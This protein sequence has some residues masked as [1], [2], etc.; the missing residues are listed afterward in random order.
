MARC[1]EI[2][3]DIAVPAVRDWAG[4]KKG[5][6]H[7]RGK[8]PS[9]VQLLGDACPQLER[10]EGDSVARIE[11]VCFDSGG[12]LVRAG[13]RV[14][15]EASADAQRAT[16]S[17][18]EPFSPGVM[19]RSAV[20]DA[21]IDAPGDVQPDAPSDATPRPAGLAAISFDDAPAAF[22]EALAM[23][24][25]LQPA[26][27]LA[28]ARTRWTWPRPDDVVIDVTLDADMGPPDRAEP[29]LHELRLSIALPDEPG[30]APGR[31]V[32]AAAWQALFAAARDALAALPAFVQLTDYADRTCRNRVGAA[33]TAV[34]AG[35]VDLSGARTQ[36]E[37]LAIIGRN[38][39]EHWFG[40][41]TGVR[42]AADTEFVHQMRV[43][44]RRLRT[45]MRLFKGW[46]DEAWADRIEPD[47]KWLGKLLGNARDRDVFVDSTLPALANADTDAA[48]W[49]ATREA[50]D[51]QRLAAR[52]KVQE[53][54]ASRRYAN[55]ALAWLEWQ[56]AL[57]S[58]EAP[59]NAARQSLAKHARKRIRKPYRRLVETPKLTT[60]DEK[61]RHSVRIE[62]KRLR[63]ALEF[64]ESIVSRKT[65]VE[66]AKTLSRIQSVLGDGNDAAVALGYLDELN[67]DAYQQGFAR[68][69]CEAVKRYT[70]R[71]GERLL[72]DLDAPKIVGGD[73]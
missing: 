54:M 43:A 57:L 49:A 1:I 28:F 11:S 12:A 44:Q 56:A 61:A 18:F 45:A 3:L 52:A 36:R 39:A 30:N 73:G 51:V 31:A 37:A 15:I 10:A 25:E 8:A 26:A 27:T 59:P 58:R 47:L 13:W 29:C 71:E 16:V 41:E 40:N 60:I 38:V 23:A 17:H 34:R 19:I 21:A 68:G 20:F 14:A 55:L 33:L 70:A 48:H 35:G 67:V 66:V 24:G 32:P 6:G 50:A 4:Q 5:G 64:F 42:D 63:Y 62:A 22:R 9:F 72:R 53:A 7:R 65:R 69:W 2:V 46:A